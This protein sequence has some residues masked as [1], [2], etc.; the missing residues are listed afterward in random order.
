M[1]IHTLMRECDISWLE[2]VRTVQPLRSPQEDPYILVGLPTGGCTVG[3]QQLH[4]CCIAERGAQGTALRPLCCAQS[5]TTN[6]CR[7]CA[8]RVLCFTAQTITTKTCRVWC[9]AQLLKTDAA[10]LQEAARGGTTG[11]P[12]RR[13]SGG[14]ARVL[15]M[16]N[17]IDT[18]NIEGRF[19]FSEYV[20]AYGKYLDE[21]LDVFGATRFYQA[22]RP[23]HSYPVDVEMQQYLFMW[24]LYF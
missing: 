9:G 4:A 21:Q 3:S 13:G 22:R 14:R 10:A 6:T 18:T 8:A 17:F 19:E 7:V 20:R 2:E 23:G 11:T 24:R 5:I 1:V 16:E 15:D 12:Q